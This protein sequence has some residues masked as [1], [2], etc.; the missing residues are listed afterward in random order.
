MINLEE[1]LRAEVVGGRSSATLEDEES[2]WDRKALVEEELVPPRQEI[3]VELDSRKFKAAKK[4][5]KILMIG[6]TCSLPP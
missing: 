5:G 1:L 2:G 3:S 4:A 6:K